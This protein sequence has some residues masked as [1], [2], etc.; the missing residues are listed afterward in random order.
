M[1]L[2]G[3]VFAATMDLIPSEVSSSVVAVISRMEHK[4]GEIG[5]CYGVKAMAKVA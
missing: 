1:L 3:L 5:L 4:K 2:G